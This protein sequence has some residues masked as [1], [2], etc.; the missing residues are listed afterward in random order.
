MLNAFEKKRNRDVIETVRQA[1]REDQARRQKFNVGDQHS[2]IT[3]K[4][5]ATLKRLEHNLDYSEETLINLPPW[6]RDIADSCPPGSH[7]RF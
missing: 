2:F 5:Q 3:E 1:I 4:L 7:P 6:H